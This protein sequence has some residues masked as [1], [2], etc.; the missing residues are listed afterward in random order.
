MNSSEV[1]KHLRIKECED[2]EYTKEKEYLHYYAAKHH[3]RLNYIQE[4]Q[5]EMQSIIIAGINS[6]IDFK[7]AGIPISEVLTHHAKPTLYTITSITTTM[8][9]WPRIS[10]QTP[11]L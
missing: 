4:H 11:I 5:E 7:T 2:P 10:I 3:H 9:M 8:P 6:L 1:A